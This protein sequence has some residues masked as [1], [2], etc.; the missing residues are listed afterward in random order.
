M[1]PL[2]SIQ[3]F[4][5]SMKAAARRSWRVA[6]PR[7]ANGGTS[8][9][10]AKTRLNLASASSHEESTRYYRCSL[11]PKLRACVSANS[12]VNNVT[13]SLWKKC[14]ISR[15]NN[16]K[17]AYSIILPNIVVGFHRGIFARLGGAQQSFA[18]SA[19]HALRKRSVAPRPATSA[20]KA[21]ER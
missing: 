11:V 19:A 4:R 21:G 5:L 10:S 2:N 17:E 12:I 16:L 14:G 18:L 9:M 15:K 1:S 3:R 8:V 7:V 13:L 20:G 6:K